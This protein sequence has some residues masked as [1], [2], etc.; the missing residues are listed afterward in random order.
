MYPKLLDLGPITVHTYGLLLAAAFI[1]GIW[2]SSRNARNTGIGPDLIWNLGLVVIFSA[3]VGGKI[4]LLFFDFQY[5]SQNLR[6]V[7]SL[8][9]LRSAGAFYGGLVL[10]LGS[11]AWFLLKKRLPVWTV[12]D[13]A[14]SGIALGQ[15]IARM[16]CL[17]AGCCYGK[18]TRMPWGIT[19]TNPYAYAN[20]GV[21]LNMPLHPTQIYESLGTFAIFLVLMWRFSKKHMAGHIILE[22]ATL[23]AILKFVVEFYRDDDRSFVLYG[24]LSTSQLIAIPVVLGSAAAYYLLRR[25]SGV[26]LQ[27]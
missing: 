3:L 6:E 11:A 25:R 18:P 24:L 20:V 10:A 26:A 2:V 19:F 22:Y 15:A 13:L 21:T 17:S 14:A 23:Y 9:T 5:Y 27:N 16:G 4:S 8:S 1:A 12:A 7:F